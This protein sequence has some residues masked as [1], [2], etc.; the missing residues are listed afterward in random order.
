MTGKEDEARGLREEIERCM[1][2]RELAEDDEERER[3]KNELKEARKTWKRTV[4]NWEKE[5]WNER[6]GECENAAGRGDMGTVYKNLKVLG[7]RGV[8]KVAA[9]TTLTK[10]EFRE[11]FKKVSEERFENL[12]EELERV[13]D[14]APD[15]REDERT[16]GWRERLGRPPE[17]EEVER[18]N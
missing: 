1:F 18:D 3:V 12:P 14:K 8:K 6:L 4:T 2:N 9:E 11:H 13:V 10:E 15:L 5:W 17:R 16:K 7:T